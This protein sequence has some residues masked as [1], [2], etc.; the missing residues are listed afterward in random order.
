VT[1]KATANSCDAGRYAQL[2]NDAVTDLDTTC[3]TECARFKKRAVAGPT[4]P[5]LSGPDCGPNPIS[6]KI[7]A[8]DASK[9]CKEVPRPEGGADIEISCTVSATCTCDP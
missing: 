8:F 2:C 7:D 9:H 6:T 1:K 4:N 5:A 3:T